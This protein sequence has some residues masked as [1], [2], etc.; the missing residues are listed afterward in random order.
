M[1]PFNRILLCYDATPEGQ[2]ALRAGAVL[3]QQLHA[4]THLLSVLDTTHWSSGYDVLSATRFDADDE[5]ARET[6]DEGIARLH[7][8]GVDAMGHHAA[9]SAIDE[10]S[11]LASQLKVD[12]IVIGHHPHG[13]FARWLSGEN[14][15]LLLDRVSCGVLFEVSR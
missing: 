11:R 8:W 9:G 12:L 3:A 1:I 4:E 5:F 14:H 15:A 7:T 2:L 10:I 6:L 13:F